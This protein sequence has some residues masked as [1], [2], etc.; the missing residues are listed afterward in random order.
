VVYFLQKMVAAQATKDTGEALEELKDLRGEI[1]TLI[2]QAEG[3]LPGAAEIKAHR[4]GGAGE[5]LHLVVDGSF[6]TDQGGRV[7]DVL[8]DFRAERVAGSLTYPVIH[9]LRQLLL[10]R[11]QSGLEDDNLSRTYRFMAEQVENLI[12]QA[13]ASA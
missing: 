11:E 10:L 5:G 1:E 3:R 12:E 13:A 4:A 7:A 2:G 6:P 8:G 9:F